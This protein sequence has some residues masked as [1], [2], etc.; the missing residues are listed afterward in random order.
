MPTLTD[1]QVPDTVEQLLG[2]TSAP[3]AS[4][5]PVAVMDLNILNE[6]QRTVQY[7]QHA[8]LIASDDFATI[9]TLNVLKRIDHAAF[10]DER[11]GAIQKAQEAFQQAL[12][13]GDVAALTEGGNQSPVVQL[14]DAYL[15]AR[16]EQSRKIIRKL[17]DIP[18]H[19]NLLV[20]DHERQQAEA[21]IA[22]YE[23]E[24]NYYQGSPEL[25][26]D[27]VR[28][29]PEAL[30]NGYMALGKLAIVIGAVKGDP[31]V[32]A[33]MVDDTLASAAAHKLLHLAKD[34]MTTDDQTLQRHKEYAGDFA[35]EI[36]SQ[37]GNMV[38]ST[39]PIAKANASEGGTPELARI[40]ALSTLL[41]ARLN[42]MTTHKANGSNDTE[43]P[44][45]VLA[46]N[47]ITAKRLIRETQIA[48]LSLAYHFLGEGASKDDP[49][50]RQLRQNLNKMAEKNNLPL[51]MQRGDAEVAAHSIAEENIAFLREHAAG[52]TQV[53]ATIDALARQAE[54]TPGM[55]ARMTDGP[56][57]H[58]DLA[59]RGSE[60]A[61]LGK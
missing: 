46:D 58:M 54:P 40:Q 47:L 24:R 44:L 6:S 59:Q 32:V 1:Q 19:E 5:T 41:S 14:V 51:F 55:A 17:H 48:T 43:P 61:G 3:A 57:S 26:N 56:R 25:L 53:L 52:N 11:D 13:S 7:L 38:V 37:A 27:A 28:A 35:N 42:A 36:L 49:R 30:Q 8:G 34:V 2:E 50:M 21:A 15:A 22:K 4:S 29:H 31:A 23:A 10:A 20:H 18:D 39:A 9:T 12:Q 33:D 16:V 60:P 45:E